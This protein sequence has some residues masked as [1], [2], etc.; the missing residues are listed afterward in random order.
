MEGSAG[1]NALIGFIAA[2]IAV[3]VAHQGVVLLLTK[4]GMLPAT[5]IPWS[6]RPYGPFGVPTI[7]NSIFWGGLWG[8]ALRAHS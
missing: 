3:V 2:A 8:G 1:K 4:V 5:T 7:V 6:I